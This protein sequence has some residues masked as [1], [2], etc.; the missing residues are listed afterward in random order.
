MLLRAQEKGKEEGLEQGIEK[1]RMEK[2]LEFAQKLKARGRPFD[3]IAEDTG[4][5]LDVI[6]KL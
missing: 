1:G 4:L 5:S 6:E 2:N 3:E